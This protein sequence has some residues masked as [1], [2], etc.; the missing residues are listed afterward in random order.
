[1]MSKEREL[2]KEALN[3]MLDLSDI[4]TDEGPEDDRLL[5]RLVDDIN[6]TKELLAQPEQEPV[7]WMWT[8]KYGDGGYTDMVFKFL[9]DAEEYAKNSQNL[10]RPDIITPLYTSPPTRK[11]F[12]CNTI[13]Y[14]HSDSDSD[15]VPVFNPV[16]NN[17]WS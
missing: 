8:R 6:K 3:W 11:P 14:E 12:A 9:C 1:M 15:T 16:S 13:P 4:Y 10:K 5:L 7:A 17:Y 2:L